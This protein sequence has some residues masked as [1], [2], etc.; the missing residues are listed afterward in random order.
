MSAHSAEATATKLA[1]QDMPT[2]SPL[3]L[4]KDNKKSPALAPS[5]STTPRLKRKSTD[6]FPFH[7]VTLRIRVRLLSGRIL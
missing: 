4:P 5:P 3:L 6:Y 7:V 2:K 1:E